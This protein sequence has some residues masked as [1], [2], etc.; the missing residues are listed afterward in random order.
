M[1]HHYST[2]WWEGEAPAHLCDAHPHLPADRAAPLQHLPATLQEAR[3]PAQ[4]AGRHQL[5]HLL[6][7]GP[8][9]VLT[10]DCGPAG[11]G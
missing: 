8:L 4:E 5:K 1:R 6:Q 2:H 9:H 3:A 7:G 10:H 11:D